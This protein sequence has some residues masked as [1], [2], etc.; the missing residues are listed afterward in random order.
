LPAQGQ[1]EA[2]AL[3]AGRL[4]GVR[5]KDDIAL[6]GRITAAWAVDWS[7]VPRSVV[8][9]PGNG[10]VAIRDE[11]GREFVLPIDDWW[12][13]PPTPTQLVTALDSSGLALLIRRYEV[14]TVL[15]DA[16]RPTAIVPLTAPGPTDVEARVGHF[17]V[18]MAGFGWT[19]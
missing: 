5:A 7:D 9:R 15:S 13:S 10:A 16:T 3:V 14:P 12:M 17:D 4:H 18:L 2:L 6:T 19:R 8:A 1:F 11:H